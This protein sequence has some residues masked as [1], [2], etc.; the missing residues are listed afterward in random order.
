MKVPN[1]IVEMYTQIFNVGMA[2][3]CKDINTMILSYET[4]PSK[5][6]KEIEFTKYLYTTLLGCM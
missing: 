4:L 6:R 3:A 2:T 1:A 5:V